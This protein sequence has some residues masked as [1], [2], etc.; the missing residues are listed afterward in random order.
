M[1]THLYHKNGKSNDVTGR[2]Q[3]EEEMEESWTAGR[4]RR[5]ETDPSHPALS[6][7]T[8]T[9][10]PVC[11]RPCVSMVIRVE[12][13]EGVAMRNTG[14]GLKDG[15]AELTRCFSVRASVVGPA[16]LW[17]QD[18]K[19]EPMTAKEMMTD[20]EDKVRNITHLLT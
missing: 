4:K 8:E 6:N 17:G 20:T 3:E 5:R 15:K 10:A 14:A 12:R 9:T 13:K 16:V 19:N 2:K 7:V 18:P 11:R 1:V